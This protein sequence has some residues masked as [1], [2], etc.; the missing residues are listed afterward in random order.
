[1]T[2]S[3][4]AEVIPAG[5]AFMDAST[6]YDPFE[7]ISADAEDFKI[8][9]SSGAP[10]SFISA[11]VK[12]PNS[13]P[14]NVCGMGYFNAIELHTALIKHKTL[15]DPNEEFPHYLLSVGGVQGLL[16]NYTPTPED[17]LPL[18]NDLTFH[19]A[20]DAIGIT[21]LP[22]DYRAILGEAHCRERADLE[23]QMRYG[24]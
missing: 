4:L 14:H 10:H 24:R 22:D 18:G 11:A 6:Y 19:A 12:I 21:R 8:A 23:M 7:Y 16:E 3:A 2:G 9:L 15:L 17:I 13:G 20:I 5:D 1:M